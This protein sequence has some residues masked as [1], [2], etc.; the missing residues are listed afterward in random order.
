MYIT[1]GFSWVRQRAQDIKK[2]KKTI[3]KYADV[4]ACMLQ[5]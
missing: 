4:I 1:A 5:L 3:G 2:K